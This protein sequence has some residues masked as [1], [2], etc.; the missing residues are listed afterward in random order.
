V[1]SIGHLR[2]DILGRD[3]IS[4]NLSETLVALGISST[5]NPTARLAMEQIPRLRGCEVHLT[6]LPSPGDEKALRRLGVRLTSSPRF[7]TDKL[8]VS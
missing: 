1:E 6:H 8:F 5:T 3:S 2:K 4:L 7:A